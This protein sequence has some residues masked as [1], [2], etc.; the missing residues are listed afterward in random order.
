M[1][2][3]HKG[4][5]LKSSFVS[6]LALFL[7]TTILSLAYVPEAKAAKW[8]APLDRAE[9]FWVASQYSGSGAWQDESGNGHHAQL[10]STS[11]ADTNDPLFKDYVGTQYVYLPGTTSDN[12]STPDASPLDITGDIDLRVDIALDDWAIS[13]VRQYLIAKLVGSGTNESYAVRI[14]NEAEGG[15]VLLLWSE[16]GTTSYKQEES[17]AAPS[18]SDGDRIQI[19]VTVDVDNG[20]SDADVKFWTR[21]SG[22]LD[23]DTGWSQLGITK[24]VGATTSFFAGSTDLRIGALSGGNQPLTGA[25]YGA[26]IKNGIDG[27]LIFDAELTIPTEPFSTF[28]EQSSNAAT[29]TINRSATGR[30]STVVDQDMFLLGTDDYFLVADDANL[31]F[32]GT[33]DFTAMVAL[34]DYDVNGGFEGAVTKGNSDVDP[35]W[36]LFTRNSDNFN[37]QYRDA[38]GATISVSNNVLLDGVSYVAAGVFNVADADLTTFIDG[39]AGT[40]VVDASPATHANALDV[41]IGV[42][43]GAVDRFLDGEIH[44]VA[45]WRE[46]LS[47]A[48]IAGISFETITTGPAA[49][50]PP[51]IDFSLYAGPGGKVAV[52]D[53]GRSIASGMTDNSGV[54]RKNIT[55]DTGR[56][57]FSF[58][59]TDD[60]GLTSETDISMFLRDRMRVSM[61]TIIMPPTISYEVVEDGIRVYGSG[62]PEGI[63][64][65]I[66]NDAHS[67]FTVVKVGKDG[68]WDHVFDASEIDM[69]EDTM[70]ASLRVKGLITSEPSELIVFD[71]NEKTE[72]EEDKGD[73]TDIQLTLAE[74]QA[75]LDELTIQVDE[76]TKKVKIKEL[77][78][79]VDALSGRIKELRET[80]FGV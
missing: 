26:V 18:V 13:G 44:A 74:I 3:R 46:A 6:F 76:L 55:T 67:A 64:T 41:G 37:F 1:H 47:D 17:S 61:P 42:R 48:E 60:M 54:Y 22:D 38:G 14:N 78:R 23:D 30:K 65:L 68:T 75:K 69:N 53:D 58:S 52:S 31:D 36:S 45:I 15:N 62:Y 71:G 27:T 43:T 50:Y 21:A 16:D 28:T 9:A 29:V 51:T 2:L 34:R 49:K 79:R 24:T 4:V 66:K 56:S 7:I 59:L 35:S 80:M 33:D 11:G 10:G 63:V 25:V 32:S 20:A 70:Q 8:S 5:Y 77:T 73:A 72:D 19:R 40:P 39:V 12:L 57:V